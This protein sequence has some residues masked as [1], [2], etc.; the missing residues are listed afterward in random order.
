LDCFLEAPEV[1]KDKRS[2]TFARDSWERL[3]LHWGAIK[4]NADALRLLIPKFPSL[5]HPAKSI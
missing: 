5:M 3:A 4:G 2:V 1:S